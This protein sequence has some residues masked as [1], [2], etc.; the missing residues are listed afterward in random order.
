MITRQPAWAVF[1]FLGAT[2]DKVGATGA[3]AL[4]GF[5]TTCND[6]YSNK[7]WCIVSQNMFVL[8]E[9]DAPKN[10]L[11]DYRADTCSNKSWCISWS[12]YVRASRNGC[13]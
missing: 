1:G 2:A 13:T 9:T 11:E 12:G 10:A 3:T 6:T 7:S 8:R 5:P 4:A